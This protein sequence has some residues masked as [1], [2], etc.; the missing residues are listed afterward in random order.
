[1]I[2]YILEL[3]NM[4]TLHQLRRKIDKID[5]QILKDLKRRFSITEQIQILKKKMK[6]S[7]FQ[8]G[9]E[10]QILN[11]LSSYGKKLGISPKMIKHVYKILFVESRGKL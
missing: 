1:M 11:R 8:K 6:I 4:D 10:D 5:L 3:D 9:R 7:K 2:P